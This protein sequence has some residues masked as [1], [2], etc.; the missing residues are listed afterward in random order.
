M[1]PFW[2]YNVYS[3]YNVIY[4]MCSYSVF[5]FISLYNWGYNIIHLMLL[6]NVFGTFTINFCVYKISYIVI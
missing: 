1:K 2:C 6:H 5:G 4:F 3:G